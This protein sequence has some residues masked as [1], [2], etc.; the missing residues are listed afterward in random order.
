MP[1]IYET[2]NGVWYKKSSDKENQ[3]KKSVDDAINHAISGKLPHTLDNIK[4]STDLKNQLTNF[5][6]EITNLR[7]EL[8]KSSGEIESIKQINN[9]I[10]YMEKQLFYNTWFFKNGSYDFMEFDTFQDMSKLFYGNITDGQLVPEKDKFKDFSIYR[11]I[12]FIPNLTKPITR[13]MMHVEYNIE[14]EG[15][16]VVEISFDNAKKFH[17]VLNTTNDKN[18]AYYYQYP[19]FC[20]CDNNVPEL[21]V[22]SFIIRFRLLSNATGSGV[23]VSSYGIM[24]S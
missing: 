5:N 16:L 13:Y 1:I 19:D 17:T 3:Y 8:T 2:P 14:N 12:K 11:S 23:R 15:G 10:C 24:V 18:L 22:D 7:S 20:D 4:G 6:L 9:K 21:D